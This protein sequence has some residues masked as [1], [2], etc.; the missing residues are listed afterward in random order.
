MRMIYSFHMRMLCLLMIFFGTFSQSAVAQWLNANPGHGGQ[1]QH[2]ICD[3]NTEGRMY[4]CSDMEGYYVSDDYGQHW[5]PYT[6]QSPFNNVFNIAVAKGNSDRMLLGSTYGAAV[7]Q[8]GGENWTILEELIGTPVSAMTIDP[9]DQNNMYFAPSWLEDLVRGFNEEGPRNV[10]RSIDGGTTWSKHTFASGNGPRNVLTINVHPAN[11]EVLLASFAGLYQSTNQGQNWSLVEAPT[12]TG[13]CMGADITPDG[14]YIY[15]IYKRTDGNTGLYVRPYAGGDWTELD[16]NGVMQAK[17]QVHWRPLVDPNSTGTTHHVMM[18]TLLRGGN[19]NENALL[20]G[21]FNVV[22]DNISGTVSEAFKYTGTENIA[23]AGWNKYHG[24]S[25]TYDYFPAS[26]KNYSQQRGA[27]IMNQQTAMIGDLTDR[28]SWKTVSSYRVQTLNGRDF[29][30]T[31]GTASTYNWDMAG[32]DNYVVA[33]LADNGLVESYDGGFSWNQPAIVTQGNWNG[34]AAAVLKRENQPSI[35]LVATANGFGGAVQEWEGR[36][37]MKTL[38]NLNGPS[39]TYTVLIDGKTANRKGLDAS[40]NRISSIYV[41]PNVPERVYVS[42]IGGAYV[43]DNIH[44]LIANNTEHYFRKIT[45][46]DANAQGRVIIGDPNDADV[47]YYRCANGT[48][49][50][51]RSNTGNYSWTKLLI[52]GS[53]NGMEGQ[54]GSNGDLTTWANGDKSY[55]LITKGNSGTDMNFELY[56]SDDQGANFT[57]VVD[58]SMAT[59]FHDPQWL[60]TFSAKTSFGGL[61]GHGNEFYFTFHVRQH[62]EAISKGIA[63]FKATLNEDDLSVNLEDYTGTI[64]ANFME[65]PVA[66]RAKIWADETGEQHLYIATMG[67]GLWKRDLKKADAPT[68]VIEADRTEAEVPATIQFDGTKSTAVDG[69]TLVSYEWDFGDGTT[70]EGQTASHTYTEEGQYTVSLKVTDDAG[71]EDASSLRLKMIDNSVRANITVPFTRG[72]APLYIT[73]DGSSSKSPLSPITKYTWY[74]GTEVI[75]NTEKMTH[76]MAAPVEA[77]IKL[78]I[79]NE[80]G[81]TAASEVTI[82]VLKFTGEQDNY[83]KLLQEDMEGFEIIDPDNNGQQWGGEPKYGEV[84]ED[85]TAK[86]HYGRVWGIHESSGYNGASGKYSALIQP[87]EEIF[88]LQ[89]L[90]VSGHEH[91][92]LA[93]GMMKMSVVDGEAVPNNDNGEGMKFEYSTDGVNYTEISL[94]N[95][96]GNPTATNPIWYWVTLEEEIPSVENLRLRWTR[97][98]DAN[99]YNTFWRVDDLL[100]THPSGVSMT[101]PSML[102]MSDKTSANKNEQVTFSTAIDGTASMIEWDFGTAATPRHAFGTGPHEVIFGKAGLQKVTAKAINQVGFSL[103]E[104]QIVINERTEALFG[105][106]VPSVDEAAKNQQVAFSFR[107]TDKIYSYKW[108]FGEDASSPT[109]EGAGPHFIAF[110]EEGWKTI[111]VK[112]VATDGTTGEFTAEELIEILAG[113]LNNDQQSVISI[114]P[115]PATDHIR[116]DTALEQAQLVIF[117]LNG[118]QVLEQNLSFNTEI[119]TA[120]LSSGMYIVQIVAQ[121]QLVETQKLLIK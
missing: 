14:Q 17:A 19:G 71:E 38:N 56:L 67:T 6:F 87:G 9:A 46:G 85:N 93:F 43:T 21:T 55:V 54:W 117:D 96:F 40:Q 59:A 29:Y 89:S 41:D 2:L 39:D 118:R 49:R 15:V 103:A 61:V 102:V 50:G 63:F 27:L 90:D 48:F 113:P 73:L 28:L 91:V 37:L 109:A 12:G 70:A 35:M 86:I 74:Q 76:F 45:N 94:V 1:L 26:W 5:A 78:V 60:T 31:T 18:G 13:D 120:N 98:G 80:A 22:G 32:T 64:G 24:V 10:Y 108:N 33:T 25:R 65:F 4:L 44:E 92:K 8:D 83:V 57:K 77:K 42:T 84:A 34:D 111:S 36:L 16:A 11:G 106:I 95:R 47:I 58:R 20:E 116:V 97:Q 23:D 114:Y 99:D 30:R 51:D 82:E 101:K 121:G 79:E 68:S 115:N 105:E 52:N 3:P 88:S 112:V 66:R 69:R 104:S 107:T 75:G 7:S 100:V 119:S 62:G 81:E 110:S 53:S 72:F